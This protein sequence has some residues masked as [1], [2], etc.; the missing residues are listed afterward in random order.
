MLYIRWILIGFFMTTLATMGAVGYAQDVKESKVKNKLDLAP[1]KRHELKIVSTSVSKEFIEETMYRLYRDGTLRKRPDIKF[2][3]NGQAIDSFC[4]NVG[5][6]TPDVM[7]LSREIKPT[8]RDECAGNTVLRLWKAYLGNRHIHVAQGFDFTE[9]F[10]GALPLTLKEMYLALAEKVPS[11][12]DKRMVKNPYKTWNQ[13]NKKYPKWPIKIYGPSMKSPEFLSVREMFMERGS[14]YSKALKQESIYRPLEYLRLIK[15]IRKDVY[16]E[17]PHEQQ[18][19]NLSKYVGERP[20]GLFVMDTYR[21]SRDGS[22]LIYATLD[23][24]ASISERLEDK[25][26]PYMPMYIYFKGRHVLSH[27]NMLTLMEY[28]ISDE[29]WINQ[30]IWIA[31]GMSGPSKKQRD[32]MKEK[33]V[34]HI[35]DYVAE[36]TSRRLK[37]LRIMMLTQER[38][39]CMELEE[40]KDF[41]WHLLLED[42]KDPHICKEFW[43][44]RDEHQERRDKKV[45]EQAS[46]SGIM[47]SEITEEQRETLYKTALEYEKKMESKRKEEAMREKTYS[48]PAIKSILSGSFWDD[49]A[50]PYD[51]DF[52]KEDDNMDMSEEEKP[53]EKSRAE[54]LEA[55]T[56]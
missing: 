50:F 32:E 41:G 15:K 16:E 36:V 52:D 54:E 25:T 28:L 35:R 18:F 1:F 8:E 56:E 39:M 53:K 14:K 20:K 13:I 51:P 27:I 46:R 30:Q 37:A 10:K 55:L 11:R 7:I 47:L 24:M 12:T 22:S 3:G 26:Y 5:E 4:V 45:S 38:D 31:R 44:L 43:R 6:K 29:V 34:P 2:V 40:M 17:I 33:L 49:N 42:Y 21:Y 23:G 48:S 19:F 9:T